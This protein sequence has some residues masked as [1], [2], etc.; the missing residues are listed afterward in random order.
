MRIEFHGLVFE[1][2]RL[3]VYLWS[4]WRASSLEHR[5]FDA[6]RQATGAEA[7]Q[8]PDE[9]R[10]DLDDPKTWRAAHQAVVRVL[11]GW[12]E[13][14]ADAGREKRAYRWL[15]EGDSDA[16]GYDSL[17]EPLSVWLFL[18]VG[19]DRG[20]PGEQEKPEDVDLEGFGLRVWGSKTV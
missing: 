20:S 4:P 10:L 18:R 11:K 2:P 14:A 13:E 1:T 19:I 15:L 5:L 9:R 3:S 7:Q 8:E 6:V 17:G 12:Q 16:H